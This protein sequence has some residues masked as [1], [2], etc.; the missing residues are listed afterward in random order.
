MTDFNQYYTVKELQGRMGFKKEQLLNAIHN[1][2]LEAVN[3]GFG[4]TKPRWMI[5]DEAFSKFTELVKSGKITE[6]QKQKKV[7]D[8]TTRLQERARELDQKPEVE[9]IE[10]PKTTATVIEKKHKDTVRL[11]ELQKRII[12]LQEELL[13]IYD[14]FDNLLNI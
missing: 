12:D 6:L 8:H 1:G 9:T 5:S 10:K 11:E 7:T 3:V 4:G 2:Y 13:K 14:E